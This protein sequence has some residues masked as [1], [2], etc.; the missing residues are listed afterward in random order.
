M[1]ELCNYFASICVLHANEGNGQEGNLDFST[2]RGLQEHKLFFKAFDASTIWGPY[3]VMVRVANLISSR[4]GAPEEAQVCSLHFP[5]HPLTCCVRLNCFL[6]NGPSACEV[7]HI[8]DYSAPKSH[9]KL[10]QTFR[11]DPV[12]ASII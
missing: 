6:Q 9:V 3:E 12:C 2:V 10:S 8:G 4:C 7:V 5:R 11:H 1:Q